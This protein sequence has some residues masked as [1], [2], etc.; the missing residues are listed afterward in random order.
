MSVDIGIALSKATHVCPQ[1][2]YGEDYNAAST[3]V[4]FSFEVHHMD[5]AMLHLQ[6]HSR[7]TEQSRPGMKKKSSHVKIVRLAVLKAGDGCSIR[8]SGADYWYAPS[9][10]A[11]I[12]CR[13]LVHQLEN[14][15]VVSQAWVYE[16][17]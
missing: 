1:R 14:G 17:R 8:A 5:T 7:K 11:A 12:A 9:T 2:S 10:H 16:T 6:I 4:R 13:T 3:M 15:K